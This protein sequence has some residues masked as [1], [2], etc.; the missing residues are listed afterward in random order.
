MVNWNEIKQEWETTKVTLATLAEKHD[1]KLGT[2]KSRKK[3][4]FKVGNHTPL[5]KSPAKCFLTYLKLDLYN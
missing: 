3:I 5:K 2:L 1:I 4:R